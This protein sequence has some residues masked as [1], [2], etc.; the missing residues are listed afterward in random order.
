MNGLMTI[1]VEADAAAIKGHC[2][3]LIARVF[4]G[5]I[6]EAD[7]YTLAERWIVERIVVRIAAAIVVTKNPTSATVEP[8]AV[9]DFYPEEGKANGICHEHD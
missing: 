4:S 9:V 8:I 1:G 6:S 7:A 2:D 5:E 3:T